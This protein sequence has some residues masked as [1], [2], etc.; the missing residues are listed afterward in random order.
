MSANK[1]PWMEGLENRCLLSAH[2]V[3]AAPP[4]SHGKAVEATVVPLLPA[5]TGGA[6]TLKNHSEHNHRQHALTTI[7]T[8]DAVANTVTVSTANRKGVVAQNTY[9]ISPTAVLAIDGADAKLAQFIP[10]LNVK[11][12]FD[13]TDPTIVI[14]MAAIGQQVEGRVTAVDTT[15]GTITLAG[16]K[17]TATTYTLGAGAAVTVNGQAGALAG[18]A[19]GFE[20]QIRVSALDATACPS[21]PKANLPGAPP[22]SPLTPSPTPSP[23][24]KP[25]AT[26]PS[27]KPLLTFPPRPSSLSTD[28]PP[29]W[30]SLWRA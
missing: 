2:G 16:R 6:A 12:Q 21:R 19:V 17:G 15:A 26:E 25:T 23:F 30:H 27:R 9:T 11:L 5:A 22:S 10:G 4:P 1:S 18:I 8:V 29:R 14:S 20:A 13:P 7:V 24:L 28:R 3:H